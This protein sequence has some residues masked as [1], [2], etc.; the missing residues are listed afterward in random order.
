M[1]S[2]VLG[3]TFLVMA[4]PLAN[5]VANR[6]L[7]TDSSSSSDRLS[8]SQSIAASFQAARDGSQYRY[9][10]VVRNKGNRALMVTIEISGFPATVPTRRMVQVPAGSGATTILLGEGSDSTLNASTV[11]VVYDAGGG[12]RSVV[13]MASCTTA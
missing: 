4:H 1:R 3:L 2:V 6:P 7:G 11:L 5:A 13:R 8:C 10:A 12:G 9:S